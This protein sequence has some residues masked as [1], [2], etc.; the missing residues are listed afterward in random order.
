MELIKIIVV[1]LCMEKLTL[2]NLLKVHHIDIDI[3]EVVQLLEFKG[4]QAF[5]YS[6]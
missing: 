2:T 1:Y 4:G 3:T 5:I 6:N